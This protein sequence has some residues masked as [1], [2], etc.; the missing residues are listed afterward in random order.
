[1]DAETENTI[2]SGII[3]NDTN[4]DA[5]ITM[6]IKKHYDDEDYWAN[7]FSTTRV[8]DKFF[9]NNIEI[10]NLK[11]LFRYYQFTCEVNEFCITE[12]LMKD[13]ELEQIFMQHQ[14]LHE[15]Q[16]ERCLENACN[17]DELFLIAQEY[18]NLSVEFMTTHIDKLDW[19]I[20]SNSQL[21][22]IEFLTNN[23]NNILWKYL[24]LNN[25]MAPYIHNGFISMF[26]NTGIFD[27]IGF[28]D[29]DIDTILE[30]KENMTEK[31]VESILEN[32]DDITDE[33]MKQLNSIKSTLHAE[34]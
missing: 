18:Q 19:F 3:G 9:F 28:T 31:S 26:R 12:N 22:D 34:S 30:Y 4:N 29:V 16:L 15:D 2:I 14:I 10:C 17:Y 20:V 7:V 13:P 32:H 27:N 11:Y 33:Q 1:M 21:M 6:I 5:L 25:R 8:S 24:P 23:A